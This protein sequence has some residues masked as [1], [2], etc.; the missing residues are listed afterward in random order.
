MV[1][2]TLN[3]S[4][5]IASTGLLVLVRSPTATYYYQ[6]AVQLSRVRARARSFSSVAQ[7]I[8]ANE[9]TTST[10]TTSSKSSSFFA[11]QQSQRP[12]NSNNSNTTSNVKQEADQLSKAWRADLARVNLQLSQSIVV[13]Y[14]DDVCAPVQFLYNDE[15]C[16]G[17]SP[18]KQ[19]RGCI[20]DVPHY[21]WW[22]YLRRFYRPYL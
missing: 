17:R 9:T 19:E 4:R 3:C 21:Y 13:R 2:P 1:H 14:P 18:G 11:D 22:S 15:G 5:G 6:R 16:T 10:S 20:L 12:N 7:T 8:I